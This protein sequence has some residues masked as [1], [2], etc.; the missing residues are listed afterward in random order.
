M[1]GISVTAAPSLLL[2]TAPPLMTYTTLGD[3]SPTLTVTTNEGCQST[4]SFFNTF[5]FG[6]PPPDIVM[7]DAG[8]QYMRLR[9]RGFYC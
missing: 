8:K 9:Q 1:H 2:L 7:S 3:F 5:S 6:T 4:Y